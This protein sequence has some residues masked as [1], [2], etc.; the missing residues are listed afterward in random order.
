MKFNFLKINL[1]HKYF[2]IF[3][4]FEKNLILLIIL[5]FLPIIIFLI[6]LIILILLIL[7]IIVI[8]NFLKFKINQFL[9]LME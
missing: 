8:I 4:S 3:R 9:N 7:C 5:I 1:F 6:F 2:I